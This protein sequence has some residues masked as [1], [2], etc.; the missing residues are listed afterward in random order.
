MSAMSQLQETG[1][2]ASC[3]FMQLLRKV[4]HNW[5]AVVHHGLASPGLELT[6]RWVG[7][8]MN[9]CLCVAEKHRLR[10]AVAGHA[11]E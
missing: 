11:N 5:A 4:Y 10:I 9:I 2:K 6:R 1:C 3:N 7:V 8:L